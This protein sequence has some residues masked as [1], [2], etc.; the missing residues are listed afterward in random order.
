MKYTILL[1]SSNTSLT[2]GVASSDK[3]IDSTSYEAWQCQ[4][5]H[6]IPSLDELLVKFNISVDDIQDVVVAIGPG[7]YTGVRIA[8]TI[9][10]TIALATGCDVYP[11]SS[12]R[13]Q[14]K[15]QFPSICLI[16]AR[17]GRSY[18]GVYEGDRI[19]ENDQILT[20]DLVLKYIQEHPSYIVCGHSEYLGIEGYFTNM[21]QEMVSLKNQLTKSDDPLLIKPVYM[22]E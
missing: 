5:E 1:D 16:N 11:V 9:A 8:L 15:S 19:I 22:K 3:L 10:K 14:K 7:S 13:I 20:N 6:M 21:A 17:S 2:V 12:L 4:S 18:F